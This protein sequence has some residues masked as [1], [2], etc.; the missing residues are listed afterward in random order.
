MDPA[1]GDPFVAA[2]PL[3]AGS[4]DFHPNFLAGVSCSL[5]ISATRGKFRCPTII[6]FYFLLF[7]SPRI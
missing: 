3:L 7:H 5:P 2:L 1:P 4:D 6:I